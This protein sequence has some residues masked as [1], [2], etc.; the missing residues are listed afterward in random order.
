[1]NLKVAKKISASPSVTLFKIQKFN[2]GKNKGAWVFVIEIKN[3]KNITFHCL[4]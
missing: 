1:M 2:F 3:V 4:Q